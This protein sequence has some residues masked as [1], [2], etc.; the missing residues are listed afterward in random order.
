MNIY[1]AL[2][3]CDELRRLTSGTMLDDSAK[4]TRAR[5]ICQLFSVDGQS[6]TYVCEKADDV[7]RWLDGWRTGHHLHDFT[8]DPELLRAILANDISILGLAVRRAY[9]EKR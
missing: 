7:L 5:E 9:C 4:M 3:L 1:E 2:R 6:G 8:G